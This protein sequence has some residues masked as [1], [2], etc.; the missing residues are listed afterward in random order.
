M[1]IQDADVVD[2]LVFF[3]GRL[4]PGADDTI[5][6]KSVAQQLGLD[7]S[8][9]PWGESSPVSAALV[10]YRYATVTLHL[11]D[12]VEACTWPAIVGF[13]PAS[14]MRWALLGLTG[15]LQFFDATFFGSRKEGVLAPN[16]AFTGRHP[17]P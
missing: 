4:S 12:G 7:L 8:Q 16:T 9:A 11:S 15:F 3:D 10:R 5:F 17:V 14:S 6:P 2:G 13:L 1:I